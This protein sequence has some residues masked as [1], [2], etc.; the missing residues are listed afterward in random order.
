MKNALL[1]VFVLL[2]PV[3][4]AVI[5]TVSVGNPGNAAQAFVGFGSVGYE[6]RIGKYEVTNDQYVEFLN[7][8]AGGTDPLSL[9]EPM[10]MGSTT[11]RGGIDRLGPFGFY[12]YSAKPN[13]GNKPVNHV[14]WYD[15]IRFVNWLHNRQ[16]SGD[17]E[18]GAYM[19][20]GGTST[21]SNGPN[22]TRNPG[23]IWFMPNQDEWF[24]AAYYQPT[25][26][27]GDA[28]GYWVYPTRS[29]SDP[30]AA[31]ANTVGDIANPG[32]N[33]ANHKFG[34]TWNGIQANVTTVGSAGPLSA[35]YYGTFD[36]GGNV[37]EWNETPFMSGA[38][39]GQRGGNY[40]SPSIGLGYGSN[41]AVGAAFEGGG[42]RV[43]TLAVGC[44]VEGDYNCNG[45][46]D[47]PDYT[48]WRDTLGST[49][50][51]VAD[52]N[53][54]SVID[55][56]DYNVWKQNFGR[57]S[58]AGSGSDAPVPEPATLVMLILAAAGILLRRR[59]AY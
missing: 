27:G 18:T 13:M 38:S 51:L 12:S 46:V 31:S 53:G 58:G 30:T 54:S 20:E 36:Q 6:Y 25:G 5:E 49:T 45:V 48:V 3:Q 42:F 28:D 23:A 24:K 11:F 50:N 37:E 34:A 1:L 59:S 33:V 17:T 8:K 22:I 57:T 29:N 41:G 47:A 2:Q 26:Q 19:L 39:R 44:P 7:A 52:G 15:A 9:Y 56:G 14:T 10:F 43:A 35:S 32:P 4:A 55:S 16:G 40:V 21:P